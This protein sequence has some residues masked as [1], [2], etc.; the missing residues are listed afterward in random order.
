MILEESDLMKHIVFV[1]GHNEQYLLDIVFASKGIDINEKIKHFIFSK[2]GKKVRESEF[3]RRILDRRNPKEVLVKNECGDP[4]YRQYVNNCYSTQV[5]E[6]K[7]IYVFDLDKFG[8]D[9]NNM[10]SHIKSITTDYALEDLEVKFKPDPKCRKTNFKFGTISV[11]YKSSQYEHKFLVFDHSLETFMGSNAGLSE[12]EFDNKNPEER[13][14]IMTKVYSRDSTLQ[15]A[16]EQL[17]DFDAINK[18]N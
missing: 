15:F 16:I 6:A 4:I 5:N 7:I 2:D 9:L 18:S 1:E 17:F 10:E 8:G 14:E 12:Q 11:K 13:K 3:I